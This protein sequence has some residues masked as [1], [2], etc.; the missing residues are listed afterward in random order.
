MSTRFVELIG[1]PRDGE[2]GIASTDELR[3]PLGVSNP[4]TWWYATDPDAVVPPEVPAFR[5][6]LYR[7]RGKLDEMHWVG[8]P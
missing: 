2:Q 3:V 6:G 7:W 5:V 4:T 8:E 1:G